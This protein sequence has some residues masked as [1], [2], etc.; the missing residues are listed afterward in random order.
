MGL[1]VVK[2]TEGAAPARFAKDSLFSEPNRR[3]ALLRKG[4]V[5]ADEAN[6]RLHSRRDP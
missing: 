6:D 2:D 5:C 3:F 1:A 4:A